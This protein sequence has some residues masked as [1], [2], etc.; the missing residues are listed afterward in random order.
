MKIFRI[1]SLSLFVTDQILIIFSAFATYWRKVGVKDT[2]HQLFIDFKT[3][4]NSV[5]KEVFYNILIEFKVPMKLV[6]LIKSV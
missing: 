3:A 2:I 5:R 6:W 1:I 4:P